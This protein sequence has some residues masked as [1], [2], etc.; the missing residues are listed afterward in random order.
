M[1]ASFWTFSAWASSFEAMNSLIINW[2]KAIVKDFILNILSALEKIWVSMKSKMGGK[3][4]LISSSWSQLKVCEVQW[5]PP[6]SLSLKCTIE[7]C[8]SFPSHSHTKVL[9]SIPVT[10]LLL[11]WQYYSMILYIT[12]IICLW[13][14]FKNVFFECHFFGW[15][16]KYFL[17]GSHWH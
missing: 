11:M 6:V 10:H 7:I 8:C 16:V 9:P 2:I 13:M 15:I 14:C 3:C 1:T 5:K 12:C 4:I 17:S